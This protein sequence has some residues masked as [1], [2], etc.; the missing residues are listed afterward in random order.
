MGKDGEILLKVILQDY[1]SNSQAGLSWLV[2]C[3]LVGY[4]EFCG[5]IGVKCGEIVGRL[6][7]Y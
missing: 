3:L 1:F 2:S 7:D 4:C 6:S 5:F